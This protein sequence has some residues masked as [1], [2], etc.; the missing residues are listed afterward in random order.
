MRVMKF[1][2]F[3]FL[4]F[5][6]LLPAQDLSANHIS[7]IAYYDLDHL[8]KAMIQ[9]YGFKRV[10]DIE[11]DNQRVYTNDSHKIGELIVITVIKKAGSC[12]NILSIVNAS[13]DSVL[14]I[15]QDLP[16]IGYLYK[17]KQKLSADI[18]FSLFVKDKLTVAITDQVTHTGA[19]QILV[20]CK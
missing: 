20:T 7:E 3:C 14:K 18:F 6:S 8:D 17:G 16:K 10:Q 9:V 19:Y 5:F 11:D 12:S 4:L 13:S 2:I 15:R 1:F